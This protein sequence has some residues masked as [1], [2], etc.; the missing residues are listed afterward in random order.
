MAP[1]TVLVTGANGFLGSAAARIFAISGWQTYGLI[2]DAR[3]APG[4]LRD[5]IIP[6][7]GSAADTSF[8]ATLPAIDV[9]ASTTEDI[10]NYVGHFEDSIKLFKAIAARYRTVKE[11][12]ESSARAR[13]LVIFTSGCK[14]YGTTA[15]DGHAD[16]QPHTEESPLNGP[17]QLALR[18][19]HSQRIF[20]HSADFD[21]VLTRPTTFYGRTGTYYAP[22]F[23]L[24][25]QAV[26]AGLA[27]L[28][29]PSDP[30]SVMHGTHGDDVAAAYVAIA[31]SERAVVTG[32]V[33]NIS[34]HRYETAAE[35]GREIEK[36]YGLKV[37]WAGFP[38][39]DAPGVDFVDWLFGFSQWVGSEKIRR[40]TG[41]TDRKPLFS[42]MFDTYRA[43][44]EEYLRVQDDQV[45]KL[46]ARVAGG[47]YISN[48]N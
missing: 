45:T 43:S 31:T 13:P 47:K 3:H 18:T 39:L 19:K 42:E 27:E 11:K 36:S 14:D 40:L 25:Q 22:I 4:L 33:F 41:W 20:D 46:Q 48:K 8:V 12:N 6:V 34:S 9:V 23:T 10:S 7:I 32:Q 35:V 26:D 21:A 44:F 1:R 30:R 38:S 5:E 37:K 29:L 17:P 16:L 24:A 15:Y 28:T 2:R